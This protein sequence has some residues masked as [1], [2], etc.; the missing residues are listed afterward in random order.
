[1]NL[2]EVEKIM[3]DAGIVSC[4][5]C[6]VPY[7]PRTGRQHTCGSPECKAEYHRRYVAEYNRRR[8]RENPEACR[9]YNAAKMRQYRARQRDADKRE[10]ELEE[11]ADRWE[12]QE[13]FDKKI[14][15]YGH[16]YGKR[17]AE[18]VLATVPKI[19]VIL[20][21]AKDD[22]VETESDTE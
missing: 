13:E 7:Q 1:M 12:R 11:L 2:S 18:K 5:I 9:R 20:K 4:E 6:G 22:R 3:A 16:E 8:R 19:D 21:G 17:S 14:S 15:E 10:A